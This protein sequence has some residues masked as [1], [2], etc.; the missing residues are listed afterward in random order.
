MADVNTLVSEDPAADFLAREQNVL[1]ELEDD[2]EF[3]TNTKDLSQKINGSFAN[4]DAD[5]DQFM[6]GPNGLT[7]GD[8]STHDDFNVLTNNAIN[9]S[10]SSDNTTIKEVEIREEPEKIR[11]WR[12]D[13]QKLLEEKDR[14]EAKKKEELK[15][16]AKHEL[17]EWYARYAEQLEK[18]KIN[19]RNAEKEWVAERDTEVEG[20]EWEKIAKMCDFNPKSTRNTKDTTRMRSILLQLKQNPPTSHNSNS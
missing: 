12:E 14:E 9:S 1:A 6:N 8:E 10:Q 20:Q 4:G 15:Q 5:E 16:T 18:S 2:F 7:N 17:E 3:P 19:N 13:Q 11:K